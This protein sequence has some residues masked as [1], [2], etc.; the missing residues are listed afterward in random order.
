MSR[1]IAL[2]LAMCV[3]G[4]SG[5]LAA[6]EEE[7]MPRVMLL[8]DEKAVG[9]Y[10]VEQAE[11]RLARFLMEKGCDVVDMELVKTKVRRDQALQAMAG[12]DQAAAALGLQ[13]G[14]DIIIVGHAVAKGTARTIE[15]TAM[16]TYWATVTAKALRSDDAKMLATAEAS[17]PAPHVEDTAGGSAAISDASAKMIESLFPAMLAAW[18]GGGA[19]PNRF[20]LV[21]G[22]VRQVWQL[23]ALKRILKDK[24]SGTKSVS[25]RSFVTGAATFDVET[26]LDAQAF[27][28]GLVLV[29]DEPF[30]LKIIAISGNKIDAK[31][32]PVE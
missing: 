17:A 32:V 26:S 27:S 14:A 28:E 22:D 31:L 8:M 15:N 20:E 29:D 6:A 30:K 4:G 24:V 2:V 16:R 7:A 11:M 12:G 19:R 21:V 13:F 18:R 23:S 3:V 25:Q 5:L 1:R 10:S 9:G